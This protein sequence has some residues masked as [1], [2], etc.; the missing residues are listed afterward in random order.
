MFKWLK[1]LFAKKEE[2]PYYC[3]QP[4]TA[5]RNGCPYLGVSCDRGWGNKCLMPY[6]GCML[7]RLEKSKYD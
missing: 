3:P 4:E 2:Y 5:R 7:Q 1:K 6:N